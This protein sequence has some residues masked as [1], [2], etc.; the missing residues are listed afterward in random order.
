MWG[1]EPAG[2]N[3]GQRRQDCVMAA[4]C[5]TCQ[6]DGGSPGALRPVTAHPGRKT[7]AASH[8][9]PLLVRRRPYLGDAGWASGALMA[10]GGKGTVDSLCV[11]YRLGNPHGPNP[12]ARQP[13]GTER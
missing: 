13:F 1:P 8:A 10:A 3:G 6:S 7:L 5:L 9:H 11:Q 4:A 12:M 2:M